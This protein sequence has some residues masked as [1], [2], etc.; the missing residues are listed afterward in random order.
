MTAD[1]STS[2]LRLEQRLTCAMPRGPP[3]PAAPRTPPAGDMSANDVELKTRDGA[4]VVGDASGAAQLSLAAGAQGA[5][6][7]LVE[8]A[9]AA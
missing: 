8:M 4:M 3:P 6:F 9:K 7:M 2:Q 5:H 1:G